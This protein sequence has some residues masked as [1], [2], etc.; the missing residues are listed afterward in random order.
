MVE[1]VRAHMKEMLEVGII[2]PSQSLWYS[3]VMLG[4]KKD[5]GLYF[6]ID[7][8]MLNVR[9]KQ[10][11]DPLPHIQEAIESLIGNGYFSC[12]GLKAGFWQIVIDETSK[13]YTAFMVGNLGFF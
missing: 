3:T 7:F 5:R 2:H 9:T 1:E 12:L 13:Q 11:F 4:R 6:C 10:D 8:C